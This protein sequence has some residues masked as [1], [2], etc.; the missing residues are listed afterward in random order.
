MMDVVQ[1]AVA[2]DAAAGLGMLAMPN[3]FDL[4]S[5][6]SVFN[7]PSV[8]FNSQ[9]VPSTSP[10]T[11]ADLPSTLDEKTGKPKQKRNKPTLSCLECV[12]RKTKCDRGRPCVACVKRQSD[13]SYTAVANLIASTDRKN[14][15]NSKAR[16]VT[17]PPTK[18]RKNST[19][20]SVLPSPATTDNGWAIIENRAHRKSMSSNG[21]SPFL[22]SHVPY[23][24]SSP[25]N[26]FGV[27][28]QHPFSNYWTC[29]GGLPE[30]I[31]V[32]PSKEQADILIA[33]YFE[34]VDP[35]YPFI[36]RRTF[37]A[38]YERFWSQ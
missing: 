33:K 13:C 27:G 25:S 20:S 29:Q 37:Y 18:L 7:I 9:L 10:D 5:P 26:V 36:H 11:A 14:S 6:D 23:S 32:L 35:V 34:V 19:S 4:Q 17:K 8:D 24:K 15:P 2:L 1:E 38:D 30:V 22:L 12:E 21:S 31:S 16:F 3:T 28:S